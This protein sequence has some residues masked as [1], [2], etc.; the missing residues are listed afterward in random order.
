VA[1]RPSEPCYDFS[2]WQ[3]SAGRDAGDFEGARAEGSR[4][5]G[6]GEEPRH[7]MA[8]YASA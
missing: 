7:T 3:R 2:T 6:V 5:L 4:A 1:T 8:P